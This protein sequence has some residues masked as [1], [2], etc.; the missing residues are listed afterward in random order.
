MLKRFL[1]LFFFFVVL[2]SVSAQVPDSLQLVKPTDSLRIENDTIPLD[3]MPK[4]KKKSK[5]GIS[6]TVNY[7]ATDSI[8][9]SFKENL[10]YMYKGSK[11]EYG[12][13]T[14]KSGYSKVNLKNNTIKATY[15][16][17]TAKNARKK[18]KPLFNQ[19]DEKF[20]ADT[21][22]YNFKTQKGLIKGI[23]TEQ[24]GGYLHAETTKKQPD[25]SIHI[26]RGQYTTCD[27]EHPHYSFKMTKAKIVDDKII[28]GPV[29]FT[30]ADIPTPLALPFG[31]FPQQKKKQQSGILMPT[32]GEEQ[33]RGFF[34]RNGGYYI[35]LNDYWDFA[36]VGDIFSNGSWAAR[37]KSQ[38]KKRYKF[39]GSFEVDFTNNKSGEKGIDYSSSTSYAVKWNHR[40]D[41]KANPT[42]NFSASVNFRTSG[43][44]K[45]NVQNMNDHLSS[46]FRSSVSYSKRWGTLFNLNANLSH[47]QN[48]QTGSVSMTF[49][50]VS[51]SMNRI[52]PFERKKGDGKQRWYEKI[53]FS[54][55]ANSQVSTTTGDSVLFTKDMPIEMGFKHKAPLSASYKFLKFFTFSPRV[56]YEGVLY[57]NYI[58]QNQFE[59]YNE[60][61]DTLIGY[62]VVTDTINDFRYAHS[63]GA[64]VS[65]SF[66]APV[67]G[68]YQNKRETGKLK[69]IRHVITPSA[70]ISYTPDMSF[71][72]DHY[73]KS[74]YDTQREDYTEYSM[75]KTGIYGTP[76]SRRE[77][78]AVGL[79]LSNTLEMKMLNTEDTTKYA[80]KKVKLIDRFNLS[81]SYNILA[82]SMNWSPVNLSAGT[83]LFNQININASANFDIYSVDSTGR[84]KNTYVFEEKG[85]LVQ[86][87]RFS[88][89][90][91][92]ALDSK[93]F[94]KDKNKEPDDGRSGDYFGEVYYADFSV[95]WNLRF[96]YSLNVNMK[97]NDEIQ[98]FEPDFIQTLRFSGGFSLT[99]KWKVSFTSGYDF[100]AKEIT[101]TTLNLHRDLH[102]W[103]MSVS[104][105]PFGRQKRYFFQLN[106]KSSMLQ[107]L[108]L[109]KEKSH[110]DY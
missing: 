36:L 89:S 68:L 103:E 90:T 108:K 85:K 83:R 58:E 14:L 69:A 26:K 48:T 66:S 40:Q 32:Y 8:V 104:A 34:L 11:V 107:D 6:E 22:T 106:I 67:Y 95:P 60:T 88:F 16:I 92:Y 105:V 54:Y 86:F 10:I 65:L 55:N 43:Y 70:N 62:E 4:A 91:G 110:L 33:N 53:S 71:I 100:K 12:D 96:D 27:M 101:Y 18:E 1:L 51:F 52:F 35:N 49:P 28:S 64:G 81:T 84:L 29:Y 50:N 9:F 98:D 44:G 13:I 24:E 76:S 73:Y 93:T 99:P 25:N 63:L 39:S 46:S 57:P 97:F 37:A 3:T 77:S 72:T 15:L 7:E 23:F 75:F 87:K 102:C 82:D 41:N 78:G 74:Y 2:A 59:K 47:S 20:S 38:Y 5:S 80:T 30:V 19:A 17:D 56:D 109:K 42:A 79:G 21:I 61:G 45:Y 31:Y 94:S